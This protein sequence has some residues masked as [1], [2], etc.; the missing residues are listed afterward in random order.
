VLTGRYRGLDIRL[1]P[2][3]D[4]VAWRKIPSLWLK[5][6]VLQ[7]VQRPGVFDLLMRPQG[8]EF[9]SPSG[10]LDYRVPLP[11][12]WPRDAVLYTDDAE[13]PPPL[14]AISPHIH[15]FADPRMKELVMT[16][17]GTRLV[18]QVDQADRSH[19][20]VLRQVKFEITRLAPHLAQS[21]IDSA[22]GIHGSVAA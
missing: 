1:E 15:L 4:H 19:Y 7:Q 11:P 20:T 9:Y 14:Q 3:V 10:S 17:A 5:V 6:S 18:F 13:T 2:I 21:L 22:I 16:P 8:V 12:D